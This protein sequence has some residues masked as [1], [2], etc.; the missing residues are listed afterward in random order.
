M[1]SATSSMEGYFGTLRI[2]VFTSF[3]LLIAASA[4][5]MPPWVAMLGGSAPLIYYHLGYLTPRAKKGLT[6]AAIDSV[7]YFGF[8]VTVA[9]L[10]V[11]AVSLAVT[12]GRAP[13]N[14]I[15]FQFGL[16]LLATGYAVLARMHLTS[17][18]AWVEEA[19]PEA[20]LDRYVQRSRDLVT[21]VEMASEQFVTLA[22]NLVAKSE[23]VAKSAQATTQQSLLEVARLF[24]EQLR[25]TL[26]SARA[27]LTEIR[28]LMQDTAFVQER[29]E[30]VRSV[31]ASLECVTALN[32]ALS[33]FAER[34]GEGAR[35]SQEVTAASEALQQSLSGFHLNLEKIAGNDG[36]ILKAMQLVGE[37]HEDVA[38]AS[39]ALGMVVGELEGMTGTVSGIGLTFKNIKTLTS[40][41]NEQLQGLVDSSQRLE[42]ASARI[43][44]TADASGSL[45]DNLERTAK[46]LP[47]VHERLEQLSTHLEGLNKTVDAVE[48]GIQHL[49]RPVENLT[50]IGTEV[51]DAL[52]KAARVLATANAEAKSLVGNATEHAV[53]LERVRAAA[54][55]VAGL[56]AARAKLE[57]ILH[58][59]TGD[60][61]N[62]QTGLNGATT[63][64]RE[65]VSAAT[66][67]LE[68]DVKRSSEVARVFG[69]RMTD[70]AQIIIDRTRENRAP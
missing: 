70:I 64:L 7:Y 39:K 31:K 6:Q 10:A 56:E 54:T 34:A 30:L 15:A 35:T 17:I 44:K 69:E 25:G 29:E 52:E 60:V 66:S 43:A 53:A 41:A 11:S 62:L 32:K 8:L 63:S 24:D 14:Q 13:L 61:R 33:D 40:K 16:G 4:T 46:A 47:S 21:N 12:D 9:A 27:G 57:E 37:A 59:L 20:V 28:G 58:S 55:D 23:E 36:P 42:G 65:S 68:I 5:D 18:G 67:A 19:S 22:N 3:T 26:A 45:A 48:A 2:C 49:P 51:S 1:Q 38:H 50:Q